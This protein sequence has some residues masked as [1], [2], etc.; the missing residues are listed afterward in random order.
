MLPTIKTVSP[1]TSEVYKLLSDSRALSAQEI[2]D[3]LGILPNAVYRVAKKLMDM[4]LV[5]ELGGYPVRFQA[6]PAQTALSLYLVAATQNFRREFGLASLA[7]PGAT[8]RGRTEAGDSPTISLVKDR[9]SFLRRELVDTRV[10]RQSIDLIVSGHEVPDE[11]ILSFRKAVLRGVRIR[12]IIH[13]PEQAR[14]EL[15]KMWQDIGVHVRFLPNLDMR[16][17]IFDKRITYITSYDPKKPGSAFGVR[18][19]YVPLAVQMTE[20]FEQNWQK[21]EEL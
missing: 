2:A 20:V 13:Q 7:R 17:I 16:L 6:V 14:S 3:E 5:E 9:P 10:A 4:G 15:T 1:Q 8:G 21:A 18:F 11:N 19:E 12:K